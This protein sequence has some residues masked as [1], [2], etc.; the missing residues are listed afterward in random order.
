VTNFDIRYVATLDPAPFNQIVS[1]KPRKIQAVKQTKT[2]PAVESQATHPGEVLFNQ[3]MKRFGFT[4]SSLAFALHVAQPRIHD[5]LHG[6]RGITA[7]T[8]LRLSKLF[9]TEPEFWLHLQVDYELSLCKEKLGQT[10]DQQIEPIASATEITLEV[11]PAANIPKGVHQRRESVPV[12]ADL[13]DSEKK[14]YAILS[15]E[16]LSFDALSNESGLNVGELNATL[17]I[18][19]LSGMVRRHPGDYYSKWRG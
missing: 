19:E 18:L 2:L 13:T 4:P 17:T 16:L 9:A 11:A 6:R 3:F 1:G 10:I 15:A 5:I 14:V 12:P 8:A 7:E